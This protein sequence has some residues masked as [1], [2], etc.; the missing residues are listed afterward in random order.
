MKAK[1]NLE[2]WNYW[3]RM[4]LLLK[5]VK[6]LLKVTMKNDKEYCTLIERKAMSLIP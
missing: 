2:E 1:E 6:L 3:K 4:K 5:S